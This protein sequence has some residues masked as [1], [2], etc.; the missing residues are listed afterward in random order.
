MLPR[1]LQKN[2]GTLCWS[3]STCASDEAVGEALV[4]RRSVRDV[5]VMLWALV[6]KRWIKRD[7]RRD[8]TPEGRGG[9]A[10]V[11]A[12]MCPSLLDRLKMCACLG[13]SLGRRRGGRRM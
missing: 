7:G 4:L 10:E 11:V 5:L 6:L 9:A 2:V 1:M 13:V 8:G 3:T 12:G